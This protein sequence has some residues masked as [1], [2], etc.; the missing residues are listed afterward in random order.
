[1]QAVAEGHFGLAH[2]LDE[3]GKERRGT[4]FRR[5]QRVPEFGVGHTAGCFLAMPNISRH[6]GNVFEECPSSARS[7]TSFEILSNTSSKYSGVI[8]SRSKS[9]AGF[10]K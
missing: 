6:C 7:I 5:E 4:L 8:R 1:M 3:L 9:G 2:F 10:R